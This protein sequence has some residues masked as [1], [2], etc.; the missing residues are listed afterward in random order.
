MV[1]SVFVSGRVQGVGY[2]EWTRRQAESLGVKGW[3]RNLDDGRVEAMLVGSAEALDQLIERM[4]KGPTYA[5]V[6]DIAT[7][8]V[9]PEEKFSGFSV[10]R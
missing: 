4:R 8:P 9:T 2:R 10:R 6:A 1:L 3:V 7:A 5:A